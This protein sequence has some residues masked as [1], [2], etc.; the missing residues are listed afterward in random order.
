MAE[1]KKFVP[2]FSIQWTLAGA[3][4]PPPYHVA[5]KGG[6]TEALM[7]FHLQRQL[8]DGLKPDQY[9]IDQVTTDHSS[10]QR[11]AGNE[12]PPVT[13]LSRCTVTSQMAKQFA[14]EIHDARQQGIFINVI[15]EV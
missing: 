9:T 6:I 4:I 13:S 3:P 1:Q 2:Q 8:K 10:P 12:L 7:W 14:G 11:W 15:G 5:C